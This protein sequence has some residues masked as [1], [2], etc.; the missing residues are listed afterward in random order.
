M[1]AWCNLVNTNGGKFIDF[2]ISMLDLLVVRL[3]RI[4]LY[5]KRRLRLLSQY[6]HS[7]L[8]GR[9]GDGMPVRVDIF[10]TLKER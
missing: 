4:T 5:I 10:R 1:T 7:L 2:V 6:S 8:A 3:T 9:F